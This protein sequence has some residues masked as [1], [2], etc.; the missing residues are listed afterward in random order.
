MLPFAHGNLTPEVMHVPMLVW[1]SPAY[2]E[3][4]AEHAMQLE[5]HT[6]TPFTGSVVFH[7]MVDAAALQ[8][9]ALDLRLSVASPQFRPG[10]RLLRNLK[11]ELVD[12]DQLPLV[13]NATRPAAVLGSHAGD[14]PHHELR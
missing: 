14:N 2:R 12:Y 9:D 1:L 11:G 4:R 10:P 8:C 3:R 13:L 5:S 7:T 6:S